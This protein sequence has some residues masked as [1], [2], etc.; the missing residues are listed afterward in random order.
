MFHWNYLFVC[1]ISEEGFSQFHK[2]NSGRLSRNWGTCRTSSSL[3]SLDLST[4]IRHF[5]LSSAEVEHIVWHTQVCELLANMV[6][7]DSHKLDI[8]D[9]DHGV[10]CCLLLPCELGLTSVCTVVEERPEYKY[11]HVNIHCSLMKVK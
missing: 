7:Q 1:L 5:T 4:I 8:E 2:G 10:C 6:H 9:A 3:S 11:Y